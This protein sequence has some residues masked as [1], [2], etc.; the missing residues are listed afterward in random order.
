MHLPGCGRVWGPILPVR[1]AGLSLSKEPSCIFPPIPRPCTSR[2]APDPRKM[3]DAPRD[4][5]EVVVGVETEIDRLVGK[6]KLSQHK[7]V[8]D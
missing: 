5:I 6:F 2:C 3:A 4:Y 8:G 7:E 1:I